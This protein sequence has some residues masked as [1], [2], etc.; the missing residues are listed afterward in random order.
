MASNL[1]PS[2][3]GSIPKQTNP[4]GFTLVEIL[5]VIALMAFLA[6]AGL[7]NTINS[8][9]Q[10]SFMGMFKEVM[11]KIREPRMYAVTNATVPDIY[12]SLGTGRHD[13]PYIPPQYG[14]HITRYTE[15]NSTNKVTKDE[16]HITIFADQEGTDA[17]TVGVF[18][19]DKD[20]IIG[21]DYIID[22]TKYGLEIYTRDDIKNGYYS[23]PG[24]YAKTIGQSS[25]PAGGDSMDYITL[26]YQPPFARFGLDP[27]VNPA[28]SNQHSLYLKLYDLRDDRVYRYIAIFESGIAEAFYE[29]A[30]KA[31]TTETTPSP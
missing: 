8:Q 13:V 27:L 4:K 22:A 24:R 29:S 25:A 1:T 23:D 26:F 2:K 14:A 18:D 7:S 20:Y 15:W 30:L 11:A 3:H 21:D 9:R 28:I 6:M 31:V 5:V 12:D 16:Y 17:G 10:Y 19:K